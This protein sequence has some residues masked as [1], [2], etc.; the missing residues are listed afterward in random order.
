MCTSGSQDATGH[1]VYG[2]IGV[3]LRDT[4]NKHLSHGWRRAS[5]WWADKLTMKRWRWQMSEIN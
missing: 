1:T 4:L 2:D 3:F 5:F